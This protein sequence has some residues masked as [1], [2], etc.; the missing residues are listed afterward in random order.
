[1]FHTV[2]PVRAQKAF[3]TALPGMRRRSRDISQ[4]IRHK[5]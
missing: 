3:R 5:D 2:S 1:M 4:I